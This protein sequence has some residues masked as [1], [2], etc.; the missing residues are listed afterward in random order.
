MSDEEKETISI[1]VWLDS[2]S[3][4][5][6]DD[7]TFVERTVPPQKSADWLDED[8]DV[9]AGNSKRSW[10]QI[11]EGPF[12]APSWADGYEKFVQRTT[13]VDYFR[14]GETLQYAAMGLAAEAGE[15][16]NEIKRFWEKGRYISLKDAREELGDVLWYVVCAAQA[17]GVNLEE[18]AV[19]NRRKLEERHGPSKS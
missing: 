16:A 1:D 12:G 11:A 2:A 3:A 9:D 5:D 7:E 17:L 4:R 10:A 19:Q 13:C 18:L 8:T 6:W 14:Q 15:F